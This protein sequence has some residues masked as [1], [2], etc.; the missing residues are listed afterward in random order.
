MT[1]EE[2]AS[3]RAKI[4]PIFEPIIIELPFENDNLLSDQAILRRVTVT[5]EN[6]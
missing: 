2:D 1:F 4:E 6:D 5:H 3:G